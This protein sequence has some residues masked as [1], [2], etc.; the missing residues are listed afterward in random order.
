LFNRRYLDEVLPTEIE[1][2]R[3][4]NSTV[5]II[6]L[7]IDNFRQFNDIYGHEA[8]DAVLQALGRFL[9]RYTREGDIAFRY[10]GEEF[11]LVLPGVSAEKAQARAEE[12]CQGV[13]SLRTEFQ[14]QTLGPGSVSLGVATFPHHGETALLVLTAADASLSQAKSE[15][16]DR[17]VMAV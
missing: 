15:G 14:G 6:M 9:H 7:D 10:G 4:T 5:S 16:R 12:L 13:H 8:G 11:A 17:V 2:A 3:R 1:C